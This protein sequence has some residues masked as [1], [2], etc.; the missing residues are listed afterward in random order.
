MGCA[1]SV[2]QIRAVGAEPVQ[3]DVEISKVCQAVLIGS[4]S[5][6]ARSVNDFTAPGQPP[7]STD[8]AAHLDCDCEIQEASS[9][10]ALGIQNMI[11][12][13][14]HSG[15]R[16]E[17]ITTSTPQLTGLQPAGSD[18]LPSLGEIAVALDEEAVNDIVR[19]VL[20]GIL[21]SIPS[22]SL[23]SSGPL[24]A[25]SS[26][27]V[28]GEQ[29]GEWVHPS[30]LSRVTQVASL[31]CTPIPQELAA[32][33]SAAAGSGVSATDCSHHDGTG[34][35]MYVDGGVIVEGSSG[36]SAVPTMRVAD[37]TADKAAQPLDVTID[38]N[39]S[40]ISAA[41]MAYDHDMS[42]EM[43]LDMTIT[44]TADVHGSYAYAAG[45][46][47]GGCMSATSAMLLMAID[48]ESHPLHSGPSSRNED[49]GDGG[50]DPG[51][52][53]S[54]ALAQRVYN[55]VKPLCSGC[56]PATEPRKPEDGAFARSNP[57]LPSPSPSHSPQPHSID[58][59]DTAIASGSKIPRLVGHRSR[60]SFH[61]N[62]TL[63]RIGDGQG[64]T[65]VR[66]QPRHAQNSQG[67]AL[68]RP[69]G[70]AQALAAQIE[71]AS[72]N[73]VHSKSASDLHQHGTGSHRVSASSSVIYNCLSVINVSTSSASTTATAASHTSGV[74]TPTAAVSKQR[75]GAYRIR[76]MSSAA[77][78]AAMLEVKPNRVCRRGSG[79]Q[80]YMLAKRGDRSN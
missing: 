59:L 13:D 41:T 18:G 10:F 44:P 45:C 15:H 46:N 51:L 65:D 25:D 61:S 4:A 56:N 75:S 1:T 7:S 31:D 12:G 36:A 11:V 52:G 9:S 79:M 8:D 14:A 19:D 26:N 68:R 70:S 60:G 39:L 48:H 2:M 78:H 30:R 33:P 73:S 71:A 5:E 17:P 34:C 76:R 49:E 74:V 47:Q 67:Y 77:A 29:D 24:G 43:S 22:V 62:E 63:P 35:S 40:A 69:N 53:L 54:L 16:E 72:R 28:A 38:L 27:I 6:D 20:E 3:A 50:D 23:V 80:A 55:D 58:A 66:Q 64:A 32:S 37:V 57:S 21:V 42:T